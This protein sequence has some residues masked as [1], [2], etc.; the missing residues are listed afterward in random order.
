[1]ADYA[2]RISWGAALVLGL[3]L[4]WLLLSGGRGWPYALLGAIAGGALG[5]WL[6]PGRLYRPRPIA[7]ARFIALFVIKSLVGGVDV[8]WRAMHPSMPLEQTWIDYPMS[9]KTPAGQAIFMITISLTP[10]TLCADLQGST[11]RVHTLASGM[12]PG[13]KQV[14]RAIAGLFGEEQ[15]GWVG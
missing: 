12:E 11:L 9:L 1:L 4:V 13:L 8:A 3:F 2:Q 15:A 6:A 10:G 7:M 14:E 5:A